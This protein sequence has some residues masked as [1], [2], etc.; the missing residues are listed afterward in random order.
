[1]CANNSNP[2]EKSP[3][4]FHYWVLLG[5]MYSYKLHKKTPNHCLQGE[6][7]S[8]AC[9]YATVCRHW[10]FFPAMNK[11]LC[12]SSFSLSQRMGRFWELWT[13][14][15][16]SACVNVE[17]LSQG[18]MMSLCFWIPTSLWFLSQSQSRN[19]RL[20]NNIESWALTPIYRPWLTVKWDVSTCKKSSYSRE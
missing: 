13:M 20:H 2:E 5:T 12:L 14:S 8:C 19:K 9:Y 18:S 11:Y 10:N 1:M 17:F 7:Q 4:I 3:G 16:C 15:I 6:T